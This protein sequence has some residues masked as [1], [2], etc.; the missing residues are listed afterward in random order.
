MNIL[1]LTPN[2]PKDQDDYTLHFIYLEIKYLLE[3]YP[4]ARVFVFTTVE[5]RISLKNLTVI[6]YRPPTN[7][8]IYISTALKFLIGI[9]RKSVQYLLTG[10]TKPKRFT[11]LLHQ[12]MQIREIIEKYHIDII[13]S[14][15]AY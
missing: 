10:L 5:T 8:R 6:A 7:K 15:F 9:N 12:Q 1:V 2:F 4:D 3:L 14:H 13:H 11:K